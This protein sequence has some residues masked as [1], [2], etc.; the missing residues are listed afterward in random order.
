MA[1]TVVSVV[2]V[3]DAMLFSAGIAR[4]VYVHLLSTGQEELTAT[5]STGI[6]VN[7]LISVIIALLGGLLWEQLGMEVLFTSAALFGL[8]SLFFTLSL[9]KRVKT[10]I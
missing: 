6:S 9:P 7:H 8:G 4:A 5:L 3:F 2:F 1:Y 10:Q